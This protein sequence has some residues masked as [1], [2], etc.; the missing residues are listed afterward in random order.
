MRWPVFF[1]GLLLMHATVNAQEWTLLDSGT[2]LIVENNST[3]SQP[4]IARRGNKWDIRELNENG[5]QE[6]K[7]KGNQ[8]FAAWIQGPA[9]KEFIDNS[10]KPVWLYKYK[11]IYPDGTTF[12]SEP[13]E[14]YPPGNSYFAIKA[15]SDT[16]G[17]WKIEWFIINRSSKQSIR[18]ATNVFQA[19]WGKP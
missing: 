10:G 8:L 14:F 16:E 4:K 1:L 19:V 18:V 7:Y 15:G 12:E 2:G 17:V 9:T 5:A 11:I 13:S 6:G 3:S